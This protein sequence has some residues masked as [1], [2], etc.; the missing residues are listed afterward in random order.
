VLGEILTLNGVGYTVVG[1]LTEEMEIGNL[2]LIDLWTP[3][4]LDPD[5]PRDTRVLRAY[6]RLRPGVTGEQATAEMAAIALRQAQSHPLTNDGWSAQTLPLVEAMTGRNLWLVLTLL[7]L[8][9]AFVLAIACANVANLM[10]ARAVA[11]RKELAVRAALG[12][13]R[14]RLVRQL[15]TESLL[16]GMLGGLGGLLLARGGLS[17]IRAVSFEPFFRQIEIDYRVMTFAA[18]LSVVTPLLFSLL[19]AIHAARVNLNQALLEAAGRTS[20]GVKGRRGRGALVVAQLSLAVMLLILSTLVVRTAIAQ[21]RLDLGFDP[22][23]ILTLRLEL[24][25]DR[26]AAN[27]DEVRRFYQA[28][29]DRI[30]A[31]PG[32]ASASVTASLP[33]FGVLSQRPFAIEGRPP[34]PDPVN[35]PWALE[36]TVSPGYFTTFDVPIL[37]GRGFGP[38]DTPDQPGVVVISAETER[39]YWPDEDPIGRRLQL[40][41]DGPWFEIV[42]VAKDVFNQQE[43][44][45]TFHPELYVV[46]AQHPRRAMVFAIRA[47]AEPELLQD[48]VRTT[49]KT[50]D[51]TQAVFDVR[52]M[53]QVY[54]DQLASDRVLFGMFVSFAL[55]AL[56]LASSGL[57][58]LM[59][60]SVAQ[61]TQEFGV[62]L[63]L[64]A[65][66][67]DVVGLV[68]RQGMVLV[69][70]GV[71]LGL[72]GGFALANMVASLLFGVSPGDPLT[73]GGVTVVLVVVALLAS[74]LPARRAVS[75]DPIGALR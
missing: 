58:G 21:S 64:G 33:T 15:V 73:Y 50:E 72:L 8:V 70:I 53:A 24:A 42:G 62:R 28:A 39:R 40:E 5:S 1:V 54:R 45:D 60:Y 59:S 22:A 52:T 31:L 30:E 13:G 12:A 68:V 37:R 3:V 10:L 18:L 7:S 71:V 11:R 55:V 26:Y 20:G 34:P 43:L 16:L 14:W 9:V 74:Y 2:S 35:R 6:A 56:V 69:G 47:L 25:G 36:A 19:P 41:A 48:P 23:N 75:V 51:L 63:A 32:V 4:T 49:I 65:Q 38:T 44:T 29:L 57:Y 46:A 67:R 66:G 17:V 27:D 61:R